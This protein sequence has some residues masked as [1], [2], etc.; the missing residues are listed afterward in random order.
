[1]AIVHRLKFTTINC[2]FTAAQQYDL[3]TQAQEL[4]ANLLNGLDQLTIQNIYRK[5]SLLRPN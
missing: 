4:N 1:M 5:P 3:L 2:H